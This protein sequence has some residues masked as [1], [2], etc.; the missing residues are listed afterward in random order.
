MKFFKR[1]KTVDKAQEVAFPL[2]PPPFI[3]PPEVRRKLELSPLESKLVGI[4]GSEAFSPLFF[5]SLFEHDFNSTAIFAPLAFGVARWD[6]K[7]EELI[8]PVIDRMNIHNLSESS[9]LW[10][11]ENMFQNL[12]STFKSNVELILKLRKVSPLFYTPNP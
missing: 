2:R 6:G 12:L 3:P 10:T 9:F 7:T 11:S 5:I 8:L 4:L 1:E